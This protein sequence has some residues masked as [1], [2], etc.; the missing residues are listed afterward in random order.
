MAR[1]PRPTPS[2]SARLTSPNAD[3][4]RAI[5]NG[6]NALRRHAP[7]AAAAGRPLRLPGPGA[8]GRGGSLRHHLRR[9]HRAQHLGGRRADF[10]ELRRENPDRAE[11]PP[12]ANAAR[13][14]RHLRAGRSAA[15]PRDSHLSRLRPHRLAAGHG[16]SVEDRRRG[17][18]RPA[19]TKRA[20]SAK[21]TP[22]TEQIGQNVAEFLVGEMRAGRI[23]KTLPAAAI[24]R[25]RHRQLGAGR[26]GQ[27]SRN[28]GLRDVHRG[29]AGF[30]GR[31]ARERTL[32][33]R[34]HLLADAQPAGHAPQS[35]TTSN[36]SAPG[37]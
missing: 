33:F 2:A 14:A 24:R 32:Q 7:F 5:N 1:W 36:S 27:P 3:A 31:F 22:A 35:S 12:S 15:S 37:S 6:A 19:T 23:P 13:H 18:N 25:G 26:A 8:L 9:R 29:A 10:L 17:R 21:P 30:R 20:A 11:P 4:A 28:P 16:G 34:L